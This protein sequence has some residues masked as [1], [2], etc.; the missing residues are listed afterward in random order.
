[1]LRIINSKKSIDKKN[2]IDIEFL[3][4]IVPNKGEPM[5]RNTIQQELV[6][7]AVRSMRRHVTAEEVYKEII[8]DHPSVG[9]GTVYRNLNILSEEGE[10]RKIE[11]PN[12]SDRFDFT[13]KE[14]YH[15]L[16][17]KCGGVEDVELDAPSN[18]IDRIG[19]S[20]GV[21]FL[22]YDILFRGICR[23]CQTN[24][25]EGDR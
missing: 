19:D 22:G 6:L 4:G 15:V 1:M 18:L 23:E 11:I 9:M 5:R 24:M 17:V 3:L 14:H 21:R 20:H 2:I 10:I 8:K 25:E 7:S 12:G 16:C 13:L